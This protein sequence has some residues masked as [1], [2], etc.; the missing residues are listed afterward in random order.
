M[1]APAPQWQIQPAVDLPDG[2]V[3]VVRQQAAG[4]DGRYAAQILWQR[5]LGQDEQLAGFLDPNQYRPTNPFALGAEMQRAVA[6]LQQAIEQAEQVAI[7]GDFDADGL[8]ATAVLWDGLGQFLP[9]S[10]LTSV[11]PN[12]LTES[13]GLSVHGLD[14]LAAQGVSLIVTCDTG[15]TNLQ[16]LAYARQ[17]GLDVIITD[18]HTLPPERPDVVALINPRSLP[19]DH[20]LTHLSGVAVA[21]KLVE[22]LYLTLPQQPQQPL[23]QL[24]D[25]VA[26]GLVADL[27]R[28]TGDCRYL[29][30]RGIE[31]LQ[32]QQD[33][34]TATRPGV[35]HLLRLCQRS[36]DRPTDISF[37]IG[38][39]IN[40]ISRIHGDAQFGVEL[41]TSRDPDR[42]R[43]LAEETEL[44][45]TRRKALQKD[46]AQQVMAQLAQ[47]DLS[48][49]SVIVLADPQ[50]PV[51]I[52]GL[53]ASQIAQAYGRPTILL[54]TEPLPGQA[55]PNQGLARGSARSV[56]Q[57]D[58]YQLVQ[59][60]AHLLHS[61]GGHPYAAG[62]SLSTDNLPLF[63]AAI[64]RELRQQ[65][66]MT[67][68]A[69]LEPVIQVDLIVTVAELGKS[70][71]RELKLL[72]PYGI[73]NPTP[74][75]LIQNCWFEDASHYN[76]RDRSG[77][78]LRYIKTE[79]QLYDDT[80]DHPFPGVW[81]EHYKDELP[82]PRTRCDAVAELDFNAFH[83][84]YEL[85]LVAVRPC[86]TDLQASPTVHLDWLIDWRDRPAT[87]SSAAITDAAATDATTNPPILQM[88]HC[89]RSWDELGQWARRAW[90]M[91]HK[92]AIAYRPPSVLP[93]TQVWQQLIG[94]AKYLS[95]TGQT[96]TRQQLLQKLL[97]GDRTLQ[98]GIQNL[99]QLGFE[100]T[101]T[102][103]GLAM[104]WQPATAPT[105]ET[106]TTRSIEPFI[107]AVAEEQFRQ[108][109]FYTMPLAM[110]QAAAQQAMR[111]L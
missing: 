89:P 20:P 78:K 101:S 82:P 1:A 108:R 58:L 77:R 28:L 70:L 13:H 32:L 52:L 59:S 38:P 3:D 75:L 11:I 50:W 48:T 85:R 93:P 63:T 17:L 96:A 31:Q 65:Q 87:G 4:L 34:A 74:K 62:L 8:T 81:W 68:D 27:V 90:Q 36:G 111:H 6:R 46:L 102:E 64:N 40:A 79:F 24:L 91:Q 60:Q 110:I 5:G 18:H 10:Q 19:S 43:Q 12:R 49:T 47:L 61:F 72:E 25:L 45:N 80:N 92:L 106:D 95:R 84:R 29:A 100:V 105:A 104:K 86:A 73:G 44:A 2:L 39:R 71:F 30:Q 99:Q 9:P 35:S 33:P 88:T 51:G 53:V 97:I 37:G 109:Y 21:Y 7:W 76:I 41:L 69:S 15:S 54:C 66:Q 94:L 16:E 67:P 98:L 55:D 26:I 83:K 103:A 107:A 42:C 22:A 57:I 14:R 56:N 23:E